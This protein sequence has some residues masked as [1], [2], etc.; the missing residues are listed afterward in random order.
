M[1][2]LPTSLTPSQIAAQQQAQQQANAQ[3]AAQLNSAAGG[4]AGTSSSSQSGNSVLNPTQAGVTSQFNTFLTLLTTELQH[5][6]PT[7]PLD[8]NQFTSQLVQF[9]QL[10]QT[11]TT[12]QD[13]Q[14]LISGQSA[15]AVGGSL[16]Y[17]GH[18]V[19]TQSGN[20][21]LDGSDPATLNYSLASAAKTATINVL[22]ASGQTVRQLSVDP[23]S[24]QPQL[25]R[26]R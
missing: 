8:T 15:G 24:A 18:T 1:S 6:D 5:Q 26:Q 3:A 10:E 20:F 14:S 9:S 12:N 4:T 17:L 2:L 19:Q 11:L 25:R 13:L 7:S 16:G 22:D 21:V 23:G